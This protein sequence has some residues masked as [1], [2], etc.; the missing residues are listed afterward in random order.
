MTKKNGMLVTGQ[1]RD[2]LLYATKLVTYGKSWTPKW[3]GYPT[4]NVYTQYN[5]YGGSYKCAS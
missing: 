3:T 2:C 1:V 5:T 4:V